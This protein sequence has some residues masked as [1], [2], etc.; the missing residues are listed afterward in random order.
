MWVGASP[1]GRLLATSSWDRTVKIWDLQ[2]GSLVNTLE[3]TEG[4]NWS[5]SWSPDGRLVAVGSGDRTVRVWEALSGNVVQVPGEEGD[6]FSGWVRGLGFDPSGGQSLVASSWG[7]TV[8][9]FD[10]GSGECTNLYQIDLAASSPFPRWAS[11]SFTEI[12]TLK[13]APSPGGR[14][15]FKPTDGR[16]VVYD[17]GKNEMWEFIQDKEGSD[18][19]FGSGTFVFTKDGRRV[20]SADGDGAVRIWDL[21]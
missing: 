2:D 1:D 20:Y 4:Q 6:M 5:G 12:Y 7:G 11:A 16:L 19:V 9:V 3:G 14:F 21:D 18:R 17:I 8:R 15:A 10:V 13:Y